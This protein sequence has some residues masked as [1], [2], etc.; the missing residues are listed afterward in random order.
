[1]LAIFKREFKSYLHS[2]IGPLFIAAVIF[3]FSLF[4]T[5]FNLMGLSNNINGSLY[6]LGY[7]GLMFLIPILSMRAFS[8]ERKNKTDQ[9][10]LTAPVSVGSIVFGKF[11]AI[12]AI[13]AIPVAF[14]CAMPLVLNLFG[15]VPLLWNYTSILGFFLYGVMLIA[16]CIFISNLS[17]NPLICAVISILV[18]LLG[19][20]SSNF[21]NSLNSTFAKNLLAST[22]D[23]STRMAKMMTGNCDVTSI[24]YFVSVTALFLV[25][26]VQIIQK[27]RYSVSKKNFSITAYSTV[28]VIILIAA[29]IAANMAALQIPDEIREADVTAQNLYSLTADSEKI[30]REITDDITL[31]FFAQENDAESKTKD[32]SI[33]KILKQYASLNDH[34]S[35]KYIDPVLNPQFA[36]NYTDSSVAYSSVIVVNETNGRSKVINYN[37]MFEST[38]DYQTYQQ[39][40]TGYDSEGELTYALQYV[41]L[42]DDDM[43]NAY[44]ITGHNEISFTSK[45]SDVLDKDN[46]K[47]SELSLLTSEKV[48]DDCKLLILNTPL[49]D[50]SEDE[51]NKVIDYLDNGGNVLI[52]T[53]YKTDGEL[54]N[55]GKILDYYGV[56]LEEGSV[57]IEADANNYVAGSDP[58][59]ILPELGTDT[60]TSSITSQ[61]FGSVFAPL[62]QAIS[63]TAKDD[64]TVTELLKSSESAYLQSITNP[65]D[66]SENG[67]YLVGIKAEKELDS[68]SSTAVIYSSGDMFTEGADQMVQGNNVR[69]FAN[70]INALVTFDKELVTIPAKDAETP[71]SIKGSYCIFMMAG[72][73]A[74]VLVIF[75]AGLAVWII[76]RRK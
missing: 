74:L 69:L 10:I 17:D 25:L 16:I 33:E 7:W 5:I 64:V 68:G 67:P 31:Y 75:F 44:S 27:R 28:T 1:M 14:I 3:M 71:L 49:V 47:V 61:G 76:R 50:Y 37:D 13:F 59:Y 38:M 54:T 11:L 12:V 39:S 42:S 18:I 53:F 72:F 22:I 9:L 32:E 6:N 21:Y 55:F 41:C 52:V 70:S 34:I 26:S 43:M 15:D 20:L 35:L 51:A 57:I 23:F 73:A 58:Y 29:V 63:Y 24:V 46:I 4:F 19:N 8:E 62:C 36:K 65:D 56:S 66:K 30:A 60:I 48:P 45:F 40:I 2:F